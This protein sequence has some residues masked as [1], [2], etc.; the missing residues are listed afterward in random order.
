MLGEGGYVVP[1]QGYMQALRAFC[2][3]HGLLL[4]ADEVTYY[5][6]Y[7]GVFH[8]QCALIFHMRRRYNPV[9]DELVSGGLLTIT[10]VFCQTS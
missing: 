4:I 7:G 6:D 10:R 1:S 2:D 3:K 8:L 9:Q 5:D